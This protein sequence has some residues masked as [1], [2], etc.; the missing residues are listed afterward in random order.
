MR[1]GATSEDTRYAV[2]PD[3][4]DLKAVEIEPGP[5]ATAVV[6]VDAIAGGLHTATSVVVVLED[7]VAPEV[8]VVVENRQFLVWGFS[9][10]L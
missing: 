4:V 1:T 7:V 10:Q 5:H 3:A 9:P 6:A 2:D 8:C